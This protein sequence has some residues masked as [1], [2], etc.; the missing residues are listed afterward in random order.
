MA[1]LAFEDWG[2][3]AYEIL[4]DDALDHRRVLDDTVDDGARWSDIEKADVL[5]DDRAEHIVA[6]SNLQAARSGS[7]VGQRGGRVR[8]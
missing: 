5:R 2:D 4:H 1:T 8:G 7:C 6:E 3:P